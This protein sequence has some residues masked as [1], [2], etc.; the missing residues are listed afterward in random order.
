MGEWREGCSLAAEIL[1]QLLRHHPQPQETRGI[2]A[3]NLPFQGFCRSCQAPFS[4]YCW[5]A[6]CAVVRFCGNSFST[7]GSDENKREVG[8][9]IRAHHLTQ[10]YRQSRS[11]TLEN[12]D[13]AEKRRLQLSHLQNLQH[14]A[15]ITNQ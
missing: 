10:S 13:F 3:P 2:V 15:Q 12:A 4:P 5:E 11:P 7:E 9:N 8:L 1:P 6:L 14:I